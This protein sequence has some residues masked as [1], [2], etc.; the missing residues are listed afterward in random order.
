MLKLLKSFNT[1]SLLFN[2]KMVKLQVQCPPLNWI[3]DKKNQPLIV[4]RQYWSHYTQKQNVGL[5]NHLVIV[6]TF[7][8]AQ[9]DLFKRRTLYSKNLFFLVFVQACHGRNSS[10]NTISIR[11]RTGWSRC[12][13]HPTSLTVDYSKKT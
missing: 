4:I 6:I 2:Q 1:I 3:I 13:F 5:L 9:S 10:K 12:Q 8:M 7:M 11:W